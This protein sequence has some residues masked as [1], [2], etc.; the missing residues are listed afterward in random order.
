MSKERPAV[1]DP[2]APAPGTWMSRLGP[3]ERKDGHPKVLVEPGLP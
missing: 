3:S 2:G 1:S